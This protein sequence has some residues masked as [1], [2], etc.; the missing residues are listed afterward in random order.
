VGQARAVEIGLAYTE[1]LSLALEPA[2]RRAVQYAVSI[3]LGCV[4]VVF[5][6]RRRF[7]VLPLKQKF[8]HF[9]LISEV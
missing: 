3:V 5:A 7:R 2:K 8:V 9:N 4:P 1:N 6:G